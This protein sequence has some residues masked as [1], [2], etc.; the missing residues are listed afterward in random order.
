M[1]IT[2]IEEERFSVKYQINFTRIKK[3]LNSFS[4]ISVDNLKLCHVITSEIC[5]IKVFNIKRGK[6]KKAIFNA[7]KSYEVNVL[8]LSI[9]SAFRI[10][11]DKLLLFTEKCDKF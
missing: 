10:Q 8:F 9:S 4:Q 5:S 3:L 1:S 7:Y 6:E 2:Y 11:L